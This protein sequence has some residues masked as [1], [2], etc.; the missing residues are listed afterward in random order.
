MVMAK[1]LGVFR[2][3]TPDS[4]IFSAKKRDA[5]SKRKYNTSK[6]RIISYHSRGWIMLGRICIWLC[7]WVIHYYVI[8]PWRNCIITSFDHYVII[9]YYVIITFFSGGEE[10]IEAN[11]TADILFDIRAECSSVY[12]K[13]LSRVPFLKLPKCEPQ[14]HHVIWTKWPK[15]DPKWFYL[16][17]TPEMGY[18][19]DRGTHSDDLNWPQNKSYTTV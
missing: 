18:T 2:R 4:C 6:Y 13:N 3:F 16:N 5:W 11:R 8:A 19:Y 15:M 1:F 10:Y 7:G 12:C 14:N 17:R 9:A